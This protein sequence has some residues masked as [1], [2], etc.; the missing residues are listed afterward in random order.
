MG[1]FLFTLL[2][3]GL[4]IFAGV[5]ISVRLYRQGAMET[6]RFKRIRRL[7][8]YKPAPGGT[9]VEETV[10]EVIDEEAPI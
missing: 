1:T 10:E 2:V 5:V 8:S 3:V 9:V 7:R 4:L 6:G